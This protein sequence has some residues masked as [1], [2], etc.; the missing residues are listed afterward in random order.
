MVEPSPQPMQVDTTSKLVGEAGL[1]YVQRDT[2]VR[3][4]E[5]KGIIEF[6]IKK[7]DK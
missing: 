7:N 1:G 6:M 3:N 2:G 4:E 5:D